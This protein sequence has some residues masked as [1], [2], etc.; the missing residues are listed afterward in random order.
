MR[1]FLSTDKRE[2]IDALKKWCTM[3]LTSDTVSSWIVDNGGWARHSFD[4]QV[5][6]QAQLMVFLRCYAFYFGLFMVILPYSRWKPPHKQ[7]KPKTCLQL[8][9]VGTSHNSSKLAAGSLGETETAA[10]D[11]TFDCFNNYS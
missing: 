5:S 3:V 1:V 11:F 2:V 8:Q 6:A 9:R 10:L 7:V 4:L